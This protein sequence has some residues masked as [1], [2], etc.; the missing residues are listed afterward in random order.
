MRAAL[1]V[2]VLMW[3]GLALLPAASPQEPSEG[4][5]SYERR[6]LPAR[7]ARERRVWPEQY[8]HETARRTQAKQVREV[9]HER[10]H[11]RA[12]EIQRQKNAAAAAQR[13][14]DDEARKARERKAA[15]QQRR[16]SKPPESSSR[17]SVW[18]RLAQCESNGNWQAN[19]GNGYY[20][21]VQFSLQSWRAVGGA[22]Y[23]HQA[24]KAEQISRAKALLNRQ[25]WRAWPACSRKLGLR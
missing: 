23:P 17:V 10:E 9:R 18:D 6:V 16:R 3:G 12:I 15:Q 7:V 20:G 25:G 2:L 21:G 4:H 22:G 1:C 19:T 14:A 13:V 5:V 11:E 8:R 24:S